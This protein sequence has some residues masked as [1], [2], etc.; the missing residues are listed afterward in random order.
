MGIRNIDILKPPEGQRNDHDENSIH[1]RII[2][3]R[4]VQVRLGEVYDQCRRVKEKS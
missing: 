1:Y 2:D 4:P 3:G